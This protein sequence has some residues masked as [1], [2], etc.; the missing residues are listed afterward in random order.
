M[1]KIGRILSIAMTLCL[2]MTFL[3]ALAAGSDSEATG[4]KEVTTIGF[5]DT[6]GAKLSTI[7]VKYNK[8]LTDAVIGKDTYKIV[9]FALDNRGDATVKNGVPGEITD[10]RVEDD[11]VFID[12][13][14]DYHQI[15]SGMM[16]NL[17]AYDEAMYAGVTQIADITLADGT[18]IPASDIEVGNYTESEGGSSGNFDEGFVPGLGNI[19]GLDDVDDGPDSDGPDGDGPD[20]DGPDGSSKGSNTSKAANPGTYRILIAE[21]FEFHGE[22]NYTSD[23]LEPFVASHCFNEQTGAYDETVTLPYALYVPADYDS[24]KE[25][26]LVLQ[27][28]DAGSLSSDPMNAIVESQSATNFAS[29]WAREIAREQGLDGV[30]VV[31]PAID[32][33]MKSV[34][35]NYSANSTLPAT[36]QLLDHLTETYSISMDHIYGT[37]QSMGGMQVLAMAAQR[38]NYFAGIWAN[39]CQWGSNFNLEA[40]YQQKG[41]GGGGTLVCTPTPVDGTYVTSEDYRN[42]YYMLSDDNVLITNCLG[43]NFATTTWTELMY[44]YKD[45]AGVEIPHQIFDP[46][47]DTDTLNAKIAQFLSEDNTAD[48][49]GFYWTTFEGG[50]HMATWVYSHDLH[51][52]AQWLLSQTKSTADAR[53]KLDLNKPFKLAETQE[54][55]PLPAAE[56]VSYVTGESG[57]GTLGYNTGWY[58]PNGNVTEER[59]PGWTYGSTPAPDITPESDST[60]APDITPESDNHTSPWIWVGI[61][62]LAAAIVICAV[63]FI[64]KQKKA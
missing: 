59:E 37:G 17:P 62:V 64:R 54:N 63:I 34:D 19:E 14:T 28:H 12:V 20:G 48:K 22:T 30:I 42:W 23:T 38:D 40:P 29:D 61:A 8:D 11:C 26:A 33:S 7:V 56:D 35:D 27:I 4:I 10:I 41:M 3:T 39:G 24:G 60:P 2:L 51:A 45:L 57:A 52:H 43:D 21:D 46:S 16:S 58:D 9:N 55:R 18:V 31:A 47:E 15:P 36:W 5:V 53:A 49:L 44:L 25:Y 32:H 13:N 1:K 6:D 50:S